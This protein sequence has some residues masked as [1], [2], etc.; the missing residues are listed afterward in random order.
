MSRKILLA[1]LLPLLFPPVSHSQFSN[2]PALGLYPAGASDGV[3]AGAVVLN[4]LEEHWWAYYSDTNSPA[5]LHSYNPADVKIVYYGNGNNVSTSDE[6]WPA[7]STFTAS[8]TQ[9]SGSGAAVGISQFDRRFDKFYYY[10]TLERAD[11]KSVRTPAEATGRCPYRTIFNPFSKRPVYGSNNYPGSFSNCRSFTGWRGFFAWRLKSVSGGAI[12]RTVTGGTAVAV[13][14]TIGADREV[15][16]QP[17]A[18]YGMV[19]EMEA[20]WARAYVQISDANF[21]ASKP[22]TITDV[23]VERNYAVMR[24]NGAWHLAHRVN[25]GNANG[26]PQRY[27]QDSEGNFPSCPVTYT[28]VFPNG[29]SGN[30][31]VY[32]AR[33]NTFFYMGI[34]GSGYYLA[35]LPVRCH[36]DTRFEYI[37]MHRGTR[38]DQM[39]GQQWV[40]DGS[41]SADSYNL[42]FGRGML[43]QNTSHDYMLNFVW[44][45]G[46]IVP[47]TCNI[48]HGTWNGKKKICYSP[49][50]PAGAA[51][52]LPGNI[53]CNDVFW[54]NTHRYTMY[55]QRQYYADRFLKT[56]Y[57]TL[58]GSV[59]VPSNPNSLNYTMRLETGCYNY[60]MLIY[61]FNRFYTRFGEASGNVHNAKDSLENNVQQTNHCPRVVAL[62]REN[63]MR[64][65]L[66]TDYDR[67][68]EQPKDW[69]PEV[70]KDSCSLRTSVPYRY[71]NYYL[72]MPN[73]DKTKVY[74]TSVVKSG[75]VG[76]RMWRRRYDSSF[77]GFYAGGNIKPPAAHPN[78]DIDSTGATGSNNNGS[79][80]GGF[81]DGGTD[82]D[83]KSIYSGISNM[84]NACAGKRYMLIEGGYLYTSVS[85]C[86]WDA[87]HGVNDNDTNA[88][89]IRMKGGHV[90]GSV[91]GST[92]TYTSGAGGR[93]LIMTGGKVWGWMAGGGNGTQIE[94]SSGTYHQ[95]NTYV[96]A[97][98]RFVLGHDT[99]YRRVGTYLN[100]RGWTGA[101]D[102]NLFGAGCG[103]K[104]YNQS[105]S[106][107]Y[108]ENAWKYIS[109]GSV[110]KSHVVVADSCH[111][112]YD[113]Y[114]GGNYGFV[115]AYFSGA[116]AAYG[117]SSN[118]YILGG[119]I[120]GRVFGGSNSH[121]SARSNILMTGGVVE[122]G[123][124]G[125]C[126]N[127]GIL[128]G[129]VR[130]DILGGTVGTPTSPAG[131]YGGG[132]GTGTGTNAPNGYS[133]YYDGEDHD[134]PVDHSI[135]VN[136]GD[137]MTHRGPTVHGD[138][139]GG[140][141]Q[142]TTLQA[143]LI[144]TGS[145]NSRV[146]TMNNRSYDEEKSYANSLVNIYGG[147]ITGNV[148]GG[149]FGEGGAQA[150]VNGDVHV[151]ILG[152][153]LNNV[154]GCNNQNGMPLG[155]ARVTI[156]SADSVA[157]STATGNRAHRNRPLVG[158]SVYGGGN[159]AAYG[160]SDYN[161]TLR[162]DMRSGT[163]QGSV[164]GGGKGTEA[165]ATLPDRKRTTN[166]VTHVHI[167]HGSI[168]GNVYGGGN[169]AKVVGNTKVV[170]GE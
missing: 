72:E 124:Y 84:Q 90:F 71:G 54:L 106:A 169:D 168:Q 79:L 144:T 29:T 14:D 110:Y 13:G 62:G 34:D 60:P 1:A 96:Y 165:T 132:Y 115:G 8:S 33:S 20:L 105:S 9:A 143:N 158:G 4:D 68:R 83:P 39:H 38:G 65:I 76:Y 30:E 128:D 109:N 26:Q 151:R 148:Y 166:P 24:G 94:G 42:T 44:G 91:F 152:G 139:Y 97:G 140:S 99:T 80:P 157:A 163:V 19:V 32:E 2:A 75:F 82:G 87:G 67:A 57:E 103:M 125:G 11:G 88:S 70:A 85:G 136:V 162:V 93:Q 51:A 161:E 23:G 25:G 102:G 101:N 27:I 18:E 107:A 142:G 120:H 156:G 58:D 35:D 17:A 46:R 48:D 164:F 123:L 147:R 21:D 155:K 49:G 78:W 52:A 95:G 167:R 12:Y 7:L 55:N 36:G 89:V 149:G 59:I 138:I 56:N 74:G 86:A 111:V 5:P 61:G 47:W 170:I 160:T 129:M 154:F 141:Q 146:V 41:F 53:T 121:N 150:D 28:S 135:I 108:N 116:T 92:N 133:V 77:S 40:P 159:N 100:N 98:G 31:D 16:F 112:L 43:R 3:Q 134:I 114:G 63:R 73:Q 118:V 145:G 131:I 137:S 64:L 113:V 119:H 69:T 81:G 22:V 127:W 104:I 6:A 45:I 130:M 37:R 66:G 117:Y 126:N 10:Q 153:D 50:H 15:F 122:R